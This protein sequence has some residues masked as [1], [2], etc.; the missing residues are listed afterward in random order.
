MNTY[1]CHIIDQLNKLIIIIIIII[2][3]VLV[4]LPYSMMTHLYVGGCFRGGLLVFFIV[5][6]GWWR[7]SQR[8]IN[9]ETGFILTMMRIKGEKEEKEEVE[10]SYPA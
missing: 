6:K 2:V 4:V 1:D 7:L 8:K 10:V 3:V 9:L 5:P